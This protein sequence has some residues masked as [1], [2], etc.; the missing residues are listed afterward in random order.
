MN[1]LFNSFLEG[2]KKGYD[3]GLSEYKSDPKD[4][5]IVIKTIIAIIIIAA[6]V[7]QL[8]GVPVLSIIWNS[9]IH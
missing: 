4:P 1:D 7:L 3:R 2:Y 8:C 6:I 5:A 9:F